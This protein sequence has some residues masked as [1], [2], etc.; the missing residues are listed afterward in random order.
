MIPNKNHDIIAVSWATEQKGR[1]REQESSFII[2]NNNNLVPSSYLL[3]FWWLPSSNYLEVASEGTFNDFRPL[4]ISSIDHL[5]FDSQYP[6]S[7][8]CLCCPPGQ[9]IMMQLQ[10]HVDRNFFC[11]SSEIAVVSWYKTFEESGKQIMIII[12]CR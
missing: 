1:E 7:S 9:E 3:L 2:I 10:M 8:L 4:I 11:R 5:R 6:A 12:A